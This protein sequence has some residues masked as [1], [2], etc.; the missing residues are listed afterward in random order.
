MLEASSPAPAVRLRRVTLRGGERDPLRARKRLD[1]ALE[2]VDWSLPGLPA[3]AVVVVRR[4]VAGVPGHNGR[5]G[6]NGAF[7]RRV[8]EA[9]RRQAGTARRPWLHTDVMAD[10]VWFAD[11]AELAA[12]LVRD[13]LRGAV[14]ER[15]WWR[16]VLGDASAETWLRAHVLARGEVLVPVLALLAQRRNA[17]AWAA[18]LSE[19]EA[20]WAAATVVRAYALA[21]LDEVREPAPGPRAAPRDAPGPCPV[22]LARVLCA[23]PEARAPTL[24][25]P[26]RRLVAVAL[27]VAREPVW[28]RSPEFAAA[29]RVLDAATPAEL[30]TFADPSVS[31]AG[32]DPSAAGRA[33]V[34]GLDA[35][36]FDDD[37]AGDVDPDRSPPPRQARRTT[38]SEASSDDVVGKTS[39]IR[40]PASEWWRS[41]DIA[42]ARH[43]HPPA[44][45]HVT[46]ARPAVPHRPGTPDTGS[47]TPAQTVAAEAGL[48]RAVG[49]PMRDVGAPADAAVGLP[50]VVR[51]AEFGIRRSVETEFGGIFY[52]LNAALALELYGDFTAPRAK[53]LAL[54]PWDWLAMVGRAWFGAAFVTDPV[55]RVLATLA[56][57][58]ADEPPGS[59]FDPPREW[60]VPAA[61]LAPWGEIDVLGVHATRTRLCVLHPAGFAVCDV[62]RDPAL[63]PL[64][65][66]RARCAGYAQLRGAALRRTGPGAPRVRRG[67]AAARWLGWLLDFMAAR[68][69][70]ALE[71]DDAAAVP[72]Y[73]CRHPARVAVSGSAVQV[74]LSL[75]ALPLPIRIAGLDRDAGWIPAAGRSLSFHFS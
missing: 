59:Y 22:A 11:E 48:E 25:A 23:V 61:W 8:S 24:G 35:I 13:W 33:P 39:D 34:S 29:L 27:A 70:L 10:A 14:A 3:Q 71:L 37:R 44:R 43:P 52:L 40:Q 72:A 67:S 54:I 36:E 50:Q 73:L 49:E 15:W 26:Q 68:L 41:D 21:P 58:T 75:A 51:E 5:G 64:A 12:C 65:Q 17:V 2:R 30:A 63:R 32:G 45:P 1:R 42:H 7:G 47:P 55:W 28:A 74:H 46:V 6:E 4:L 56:G 53:G 57:R 18:R 16:G 9:L 19:P 20:E 31:R 69:A 60:V 66:A 38:H 62:P